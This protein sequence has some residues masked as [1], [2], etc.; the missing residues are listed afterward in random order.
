LQT[1]KAKVKALD[2]QATGEDVLRDED[3]MRWSA[4]TVVLLPFLLPPLCASDD[5]LVVGNALSPGDLIVSEAGAFALGFFSPSNSTPAKL[6]L[7]IWYNGI[8]E[9]T[10]VWVANRES[11]IIVTGGR[12][13]SAARFALTNTSNLVLSDA[14][15][16]VVWETNNVDAGKTN[17]SSSASGTV[18]TL[19]KAGNLVLRS[20][21]GTTVWQ[22]FD[23]PTDTFLP[24]MKLHVNHGYLPGDRLVSWKSPVD[25]SPGSFTYGADPVTFIQ[26]FIWNGSRPLHRSSV[27]TGYKVLSEYVAKSSAIVYFTVVDLDE[28]AYVSFSI[29]D[30]AAPTR[31]VM[32]YSG[33]LELQSWNTASVA[34]A[35]LGALPHH[36]CSRYGYCGPFGYCDHTSGAGLASCKCPVGFAPKS[37]DE[38]R[39]GKFSQGCQRREQLRCG[40]HGDGFLA[41][42]DMKAPDGFVLV[43]NKS[44][45]ECAA[46][47]SL[48]CSCVA[49][50][51]ANFSGSSKWNSTRC[52]VWVGE[53]IDMEKIGSNAE[54]SETLYLRLAGLD[55]GT[56]HL[57][58]L[59]CACASTYRKHSPQKANN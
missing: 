56:N 24:T 52:L 33:R 19:T 7:G 26:T 50:A 8:P 29:T 28:D 57:L 48:N 30:G 3:T 59:L 39:S 10:A 15:G 36:D 43:W 40:G 11:P 53:L 55:T 18:A 12:R 37:S 17:G 34:W 22:S 49:Y 38:W 46:Q 44:L 35:T 2:V 41:L 9:L 1:K 51:Y 45:D 47:C 31:Y 58:Q 6:Y 27:W 20:Q 21:N 13:S 32:S 42:P 54:G 16:R 5:Q 25:P 14:D 23:H 4:C